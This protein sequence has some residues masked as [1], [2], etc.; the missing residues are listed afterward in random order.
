MPPKIVISFLDSG[1]VF[2]SIRF[3]IKMT[4]TSVQNGG[5]QTLFREGVKF[6][7]QSKI[8]KPTSRT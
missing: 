2:S 1:E 8:L 7:N 5:F 4:K 6:S 3:K